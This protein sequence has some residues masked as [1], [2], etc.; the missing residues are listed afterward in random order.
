MNFYKAKCQH[1]CISCNTIIE[2]GTYYE[3][4][5]N[6]CYCLQCSSNCDMIIEH[7]SKKSHKKK[8]PIR[9]SK[10]FDEIMKELAKILGGEYTVGNGPYIDTDKLMYC[11]TCK[12]YREIKEYEDHLWSSSTMIAENYLPC[13][14]PKRTRSLWQKHFAIPFIKR[15]WFPKNCRKWEKKDNA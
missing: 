6:K 2:K 12:Y 1:I 3:R 5:N 8:P 7:A 11:K 9:I 13:N 15:T 4:L 14:I 10:E